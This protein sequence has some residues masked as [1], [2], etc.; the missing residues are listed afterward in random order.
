MKKEAQNGNPM[1]LVKVLNHPLT[2]KNIIT[3][4]EKGVKIYE[5]TTN[6]SNRTDKKIL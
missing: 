2:F 6:E 3:D 4:T 1:L 5:Q